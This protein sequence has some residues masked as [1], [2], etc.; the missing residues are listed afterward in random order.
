[1]GGVKRAEVGTMKPSRFWLEQAQSAFM[2]GKTPIIRD[3]DPLRLHR[4]LYKAAKVR[5]YNW[6]FAQD[7]KGGVV[8]VMKDKDGATVVK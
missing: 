7:G 8:V 4:R 5:G 3:G 1:M 6:H 2:I